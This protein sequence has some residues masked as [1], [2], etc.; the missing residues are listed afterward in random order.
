M[1]LVQMTCQAGVTLIET[2]IALLVF[3]VGILAVASMQTTSMRSNA[4][5]NQVSQKVFS[6]GAAI[7]KLMILPFD[8]V[9]LVDEDKTY[10][11]QKPDH[12]PFSIPGSS[13]SIEW[14]IQDDFPEPGLKRIS[15][16]VSDQ[17]PSIRSGK[18]R[19]EFIRARDFY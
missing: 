19:Y 1:K 17:R 3:S 5:A 14:E 18:N 9:L 6:A 12:G 11:P 4:Y 16:M 10:N 13:F 7:E 15:V 2:M 8:D